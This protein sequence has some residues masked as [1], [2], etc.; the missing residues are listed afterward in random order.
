MVA[1]DDAQVAASCD[2]TKIIGMD[3]M[4]ATCDPSSSGHKRVL[5]ITNIAMPKTANYKSKAMP[6]WPATSSLLLQA[7]NI[8]VTPTHSEVIALLFR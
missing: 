6:T 1:A 7:K 2:R 8:K 3:D 4:L 5:H